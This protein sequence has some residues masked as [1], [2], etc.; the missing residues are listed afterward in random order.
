MLEL[1]IENH[2]LTRNIIFMMHMNS[3]R[4]RGKTKR[5]EIV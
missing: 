4:E 2:K 3:K 5:L 1:N